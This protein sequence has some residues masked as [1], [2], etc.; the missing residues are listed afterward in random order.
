MPGSTT[1][2][3][4]RTDIR[5]SVRDAL[6][7]LPFVAVVTVFLIVPTVTV[8]VMAFFADGSFSLDRIA[9][10]FSGTA[11][12]ALAK[13]IVLSASTALIGAVLGAVLAWLI[14][15]SPPASMLRRAVLALCSVLAQF[16]G[17]A[18][19]FAFLATIG[20]NG[21]LTLWVKEN[22]GWDLAGSGWLY[23][24]P[25]L[26]LVYTYFQIPLMVI[27]FLP[28]L[29]GLREQWREAAVSLGAS[30]WQY[31]REVAVPLLSPAFLGSAL[32]LF[33]NAFA[34][35]ATAA[36]LV[37]QGSPIVPLLIRAALTS[38]VVLGQSGFAYALAC[39]MIVVVAAVMIA[40]N[41]LVRRTARWLK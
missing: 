38:E 25:G 9:A 15:S 17:V 3:D 7:L 29:E 24:L 2:R 26:I 21:V 27:V 31:L 33:A 6:P 39:E 1:R 40:Y 18:L 10:L 32:L 37:S 8:I 16:G 41:A 22:L 34:A 11:L 5:G 28:A 35:Y 23:G 20:L 30:Q 13:S 19:A 12:A 14:V 36:A 4:L